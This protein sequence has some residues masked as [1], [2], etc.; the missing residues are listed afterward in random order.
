MASSGTSREP[1][2]LSVVSVVRTFPVLLTYGRETAVKELKNA[3]KGSEH[4]VI[5][6]HDQ[7][8]AL[9]KEILQ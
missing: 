7:D 9:T 4:I 3:I 8:C 6:T 5:M 2:N 1:L